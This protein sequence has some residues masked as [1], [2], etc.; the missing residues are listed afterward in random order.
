MK[1]STSANNLTASPFKQVTNALDI[2]SVK[3]VSGAATETGAVQKCV[4]RE[5]HLID[6][7]TS[8]DTRTGFL[9][10]RVICTK[11][12]KQCPGVVTFKLPQ[13]S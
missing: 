13:H 1:V 6:V 4:E 11:D 10:R 5:M 12:Q 3:N 2:R 8:E 7:N 9:K